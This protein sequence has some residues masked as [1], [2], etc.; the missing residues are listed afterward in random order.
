MCVCLCVGV[1]SWFAG[2]IEQVSMRLCGC[3]AFWRSILVCV[4]V[5]VVR[6]RVVCVGVRGVLAEL[7]EGCGGRGRC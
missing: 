1:W 6:V 2:R 7:V 5:R 3:A 4:P